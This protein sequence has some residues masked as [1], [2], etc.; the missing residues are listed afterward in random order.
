MKYTTIIF[1]NIIF[2]VML[3]LLSSCGRY[4][5]WYKCTFTG[6][7]YLSTI[8]NSTCKYQAEIA[9]YDQFQTI[10]LFHILWLNQEV[11]DVFINMRTERLGF[12]K[13]QKK[14]RAH[15]EYKE[16]KKYIA[17]YILTPL[18]PCSTLVR[19]CRDEP[20]WSAY[21]KIEDQTYTPDS[22][23]I[24]DIDPEYLCIIGAKLIKYR[25][26]YKII[27]DLEKIQ[28]DHKKNLG[29]MPI[30]FMI[31]AGCFKASCPW[32]LPPSTTFFMAHEEEMLSKSD[33]KYDNAIK[34]TKKDK[35]K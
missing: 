15:R 28:E 11:R 35:E 13:Q 8:C 4:I 14:E 16:L 1:I 20:A 25:R 12:S 26:P 21:L 33:N 31:T 10:G 2:I 23:K 9:L 3:T 7:E 34:E 32:V 29:L 19:S 22:F 18:F 6:G 17:F 24:C 30:E 27:F 5:Q